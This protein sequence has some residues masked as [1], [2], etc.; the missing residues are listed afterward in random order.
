VELN[1]IL[2]SE[3]FMQSSIISTI[4]RLNDIVECFTHLTQIVKIYDK[5][6]ILKHLLKQGKLFLDT[7]VKKVM[8]ILNINFKQHHEDIVG[9][10]KI[11]QQ[12]TRIFQS[13]CNDSKIMKDLVLT[14]NV[15]QAKKILETL[16]FQV[17]IMLEDNSCLQAFW[18]GNLR[19]RNIQGNFVSSQFVQESK[20]NIKANIDDID[21]A[22]NNEEENDIDNLLG[23][24]EE[25]G[26][27]NRDSTN[28][29][30]KEKIQ[31]KTKNLALK[32]PKSEEMVESDNSM[33]E[34]EDE[35]D[36]V[37]EEEME[38]GEVE[39][40]V[41]EG[42]IEEEVEEGEIEE[43]EEEEDEIE[44]ENNKSESISPSRKK[45]NEAPEIVVSSSQRQNP[46]SIHNSISDSK[47][48]KSGLSDKSSSTNSNMKNSGE[49]INSKSLE[50]DISP[51]KP[52]LRKKKRAIISDDED[53]EDD[54]V[55][56]IKDA[57]AEIIGDVEDGLEDIVVK[58]K[59]KKLKRSKN[60]SKSKRSVY[61]LS[62][63]SDDDDDDEKDKTEEN[64]D[65]YD[66]NDSFIDDGSVLY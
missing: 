58:P 8:P 49:I 62:Q 43:E 25:E 36:E 27:E 5:R 11:L 23:S 54:E 6:T 51:I 12:S 29:I 52:I 63:A 40:E 18:I 64:M 45:K 53:D 46:P 16:L 38:E 42:E 30:K 26:K 17:K 2:H 56:V 1:N 35:E 34:D 65:E 47:S 14:S 15:P 32:Q 50:M 7:F 55:Q 22:I 31:K 66:Y 9:L 48:N 57:E 41:E 13:V 39:E 37:E 44:T 24:D 21:S 19:H 59:K 4:K 3:A 33:D 61:L 28:Q 60:L 10:L 20:E